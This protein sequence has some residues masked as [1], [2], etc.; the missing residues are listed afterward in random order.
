MPG[1]NGKNSRV[2]LIVFAVF[3]FIVGVSIAVAILI[4]PVLTQTVMAPPYIKEMRQAAETWRVN[5]PQAENSIH[6][7]FKRAEKEG[8]PARDLITMH[9]EYAT[10]LYQSGDSGEGSAEIGRAIAICPKDPAKDSAEADLLT[11]L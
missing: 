11:H 1:D 4:E 9:R 5:R 6:E 7:A 8:A 2:K 3:C 10:L